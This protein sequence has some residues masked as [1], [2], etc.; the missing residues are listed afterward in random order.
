[1][2]DSLK[3]HGL[4][5]ARLP[6]YHLL[7]LLKL[8]FCW[9]QSFSIFSCKEH[10]QSDFGIYHLVI[11]MCRAVS[12]VG[13]KECLLW[14]VCFL[15]KILLAFAL[16]HFVLQG[17]TCLLLQ[18]SLDFLLLHSSPL[19]WKGHLFLGVSSRRSCRSSQNRSTSASSASV[20]GT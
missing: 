9:L 8:V 7:S 6:L 4:Q 12:Y 19:W 17:Q 2:S 16:L 20:V 18:V 14:P 15:D 10:N 1:M 5:H 3:L 13:G 11:S